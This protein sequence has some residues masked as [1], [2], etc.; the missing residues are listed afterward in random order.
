VVIWLGLARIVEE[1]VQVPFASM[2]GRVTIRFQQYWDRDLAGAQMDAMSGGNS[3]PHP[4]TVRRATGQDGGT[5][6]R[7]NPARCVTLGQP[8]SFL[9]KLVK[10]RRLY[11]GMTLDTQV[12]PSKI[13]GEENDKIGRP[14]LRV[15]HKG[16]SN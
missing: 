14:I 3:A 8:H 1:P 16:K 6:G 9:G 10:I 7:T 15:A 5:R 2:T 11:Q 12:S 4:V 13:V